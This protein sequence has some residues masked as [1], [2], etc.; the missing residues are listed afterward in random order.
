M[1]SS[2][3]ILESVDPEIRRIL[4][5]TGAL[6][7]GHFLLTSGRH[8]AF[9]FP[10]MRLLQNPHWA[11]LARALWRGARR[12]PRG[13]TF[14]PAVGGTSGVR[15]GQQLPNCARYSPRV[16]GTMTTRRSLRFIQAKYPAGGRVVT[17]GEP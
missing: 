6:L 17:T 14:A 3:M 1:Q 11:S 13:A 12:T 4:L 5:E 9:L 15:A 8:S 2:E 7:H 16:E 10:G